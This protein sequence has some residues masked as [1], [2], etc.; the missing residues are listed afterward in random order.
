MGEVRVYGPDGESLIVTE[1]QISSPDLYSYRVVDGADPLG[2]TDLEEVR[3]NL[4]TAQSADWWLDATALTGAPTSSSSSPSSSTRRARRTSTSLPQAGY[5]FKSDRRAGHGSL[6]RSEMV[7][8]L[9]FAG[10]GVPHGT[11]AAARTVDLAPTILRYLGVP[12]DPE[13]M[14]GND[15]SI[16]R[17]PSANS[18]GRKMRP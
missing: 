10:P 4:G 5:G 6:S 1:E 2:Y 16:G 11:L 13:E 18:P 9:V 8:P 14:D 15:L 3:R 17:P 7:V 12:F